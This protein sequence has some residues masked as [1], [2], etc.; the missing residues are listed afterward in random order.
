MEKANFAIS[1]DVK[2]KH[3]LLLSALL[4][5]CGQTYGLPVEPT[6]AET[7][8]VQKRYFITLA[9]GSAV[10]DVNFEI[11]KTRG[12]K[13]AMVA[14]SKNDGTEV[15][16]FYFFSNYRASASSCIGYDRRAG[17]FVIEL[18]NNDDYRSGKDLLEM[19]QKFIRPYASGTIYADVPLQYICSADVAGEP[20]AAAILDKAADKSRGR[21]KKKLPS[22]RLTGYDIRR[23]YWEL[24]AHGDFNPFDFQI[25]NLKA[26]YIERQARRFGYTQHADRETI[27]KRLEEGDRETADFVSALLTINKKKR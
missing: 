26:D 10:P 11:R 27:M 24:E 17:A 23:D 22:L 2:M 7:Q 9:D 13:P 1:N 8:D 21:L 5:L 25:V 18:K 3:I 4:M 15:A 19:A 14:V 16:R 6:G 12:D 20:R